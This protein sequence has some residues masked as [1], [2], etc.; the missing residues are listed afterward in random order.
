MENTLSPK[1]EVTGFWEHSHQGNR[2]CGGLILI[3]PVDLL[4]CPDD[5]LIRPDYI[6][7]RP[8]AMEI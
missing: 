8:A 2:G 6:L 7:I 4:Y 5:T 3:R 1:D